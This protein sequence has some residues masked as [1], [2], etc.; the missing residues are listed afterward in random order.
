MTNLLQSQ[1]LSDSCGGSVAS[2]SASNSQQQQEE[3][4]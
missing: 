2:Y 4:P 3:A 1:T